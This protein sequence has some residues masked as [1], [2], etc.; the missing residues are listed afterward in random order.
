MV[1]RR[2]GRAPG[3]DQDAGHRAADRRTMGLGPQRGRNSTSSP[4][5][6]RA[7]STAPP[8][9]PSQSATASSRSAAAGAGILWASA[10]QPVALG[11]AATRSGGPAMVA[12][13]WIS[14]GA[15]RSYSRRP[16]PRRLPGVQRGRFQHRMGLLLNCPSPGLGLDSCLAREGDTF[17]GAEVP[18][19]FHGLACLAGG[20]T[21]EPQPGPDWPDDSGSMVRPLQA[22]TPVA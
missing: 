19:A 7:L 2:A 14:A 15:G 17:D 22:C 12:S 1:T 8:G 5:W 10:C 9:W 11:G 3:A 21:L 4:G 18:F 16:G 20:E 13:A 6:C